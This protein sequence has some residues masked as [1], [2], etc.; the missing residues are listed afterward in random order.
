MDRQ[1]D[2]QVRLGRLR[3]PFFVFLHDLAV[4]PVAWFGAYWLRFNLGE[5]PP[6]FMDAALG[7]L[8]LVVGIQL[9][10]FVYFGLYRGHWRFA[11]VPDLLRILKAVVL[12]TLA[13]V[14]VLF[15]FTRLQ[16]IP[17]SVFP[18]YAVLLTGLLGG[19]RLFYRWFKDRRLYLGQGRR[20]LIVGAGRAGEMLARDLLRDPHRSLNPVGFV[21]DDPR[22]QGREIHGIR[23]LGTGSQFPTLVAEHDVDLVLLA[24]PSA[25]SAQIRRLVEQCEAAGVPFRMLPRMA[26]LV[27]GRVSVD[28]LRE[29]SIE[30][31]L[32]RDPVELD[33][34]AIHAGLS[35]RRVLVSGGGG[36]IGSELCRQVVR[37]GPS[38]LIIFEKSE[39]NLYRIE[40]ELRRAF[41][42][43]PIR[44]LLGDVTDPVAVDRLF[45]AQRPHVVI[46][47]AAY[48]HVPLLENQVREA[49]LNNVCGTRTMALA[50]DRH[51]SEIFVL[52]S[53]DKAVNPANVMGASKRVAE[54]FCQN[55]DRR[56]R[57]R[58]VTVR[59]GNVLGSAG[60][61]VPL[62]QEQIRAG[63]P[64]TVTH[65]DMTRYFMTIPEACQLI[66]QAGV[67]GEGGEIYVLDMGEPVKITYLAEQMIRLA[68]LEPGKDIEI[69]FSGLRPGEKLY[70]ELFHEQESLR[71]TEH[72][73][74][75]L[76][77]HR[78]VDWSELEQIFAAMEQACREFD[79]A[80]LREC[81]ARLVP[82]LHSE[83][84]QLSDNS[85][86]ILHLEP[87]Q[88]T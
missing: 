29:V 16:G 67:M 41:S 28:A 54:I 36:S 12:G 55:F 8:P 3:H 4:V 64:V 13:V 37:L 17:R 83:N 57:T 22:K 39:Y 84:P 30:D 14:A 21:D 50:A 38:E 18:L 85:T 1:A 32:G 10:A 9:S 24:V 47:A 44:A 60:S 71:P 35:G 19:P 23:V 87:R 49:V 15:L 75:R 42:Q 56:S 62:F 74:I 69:V 53:T 34:R 27:A 81:L 72:D 45:E 65:K 88:R 82:E 77:A 63:G 20:V 11:S 70:E 48:K 76:A 31:L 86:N 7:W 26:D 40:M 80:R 78:V 61:V 43:V 59:F 66:L 58:F 52:V 79:E 51:G 68:G 73:K 33:R 6:E 25:R 5:I 2:G 46:H